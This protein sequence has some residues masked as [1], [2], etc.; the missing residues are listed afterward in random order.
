MSFRAFFAIQTR[1]TKN[2]K[3][4]R[5]ATGANVLSPSTSRAALLIV[6][7]CYTLARMDWKTQRERLS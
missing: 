7:G 6:I 5:T 1:L 3:K 4:Q 2:A